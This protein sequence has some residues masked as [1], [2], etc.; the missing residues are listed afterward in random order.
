MWR[1]GVEDCCA[2]R[3][4]REPLVQWLQAIGR[5]VTRSWE[6]SFMKKADCWKFVGLVNWLKQPIGC[7]AEREPREWAPWPHLL[8]W[9]LAAAWHW[10]K[11]MG[12]KTVWC[13]PY[14]MASWTTEMDGKQGIFRGPDRRHRQNDSQCLGH[15]YLCP[16]SLFLPQLLLFLPYLLVRTQP[17]TSIL[18]RITVTICNL[19][20]TID[21][22]FPSYKIT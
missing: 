3:V 21:I 5:V 12:K 15:G 11:P 9:S 1:V 8:T 22:W 17:N 13:S 4:L 20:F 2:W 14:G 16:S 7:L 19:D 10:L 6:G 18:Q